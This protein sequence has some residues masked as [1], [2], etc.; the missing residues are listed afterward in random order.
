MLRA[1]LLLLLAPVVEGVTAAADLYEPGICTPLPSHGVN[2]STERKFCTHVCSLFCSV[3]TVCMPVAA[4]ALRE[5]AIDLAPTLPHPPPT[6]PPNT[7]AISDVSLQ[8]VSYLFHAIGAIGPSAHTDP[9]VAAALHADLESAAPA[10]AP[11]SRRQAQASDSDGRAATFTELLEQSA[12]RLE[13]RRYYDDAFHEELPDLN[14][15]APALFCKR[16]QATPERASSRSLTQSLRNFRSTAMHTRIY[17][18]H[19]LHTRYV[20]C[21]GLTGH[22]CYVWARRLPL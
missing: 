20:A 6:H 4:G 1:V 17:T 19:I 15:A 12:A 8:C 2:L 14:A 5:L 7:K 16:D 11:H 13:V 21:T 10:A 9:S 22:A 3:R 18:P